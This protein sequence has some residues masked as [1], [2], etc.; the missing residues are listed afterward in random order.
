MKIALIIER[1]DIRLGG[2]ERSISELSHAMIQQGLDVTLLAAQGRAGE[3]PSE[4]LCG[5]S[6][7]R[8]DHTTF[9]EALRRHLSNHSYDITHT[10]LPFGFA[11]IYQPRG[12]SYA[13]T[14]LRTAASHETPLK[15]WVKRITAFTNRRRQQWFAAERS[16][17]TG[18]EG[19]VIAA[20]SKYV[21]QQFK[22]HYNTPED[23]L[24]LIANGVNTDQPTD[25]DAVAQFTQDVRRQ[26]E[27]SPQSEP[28]FYL[29]GAHN[30]RLKGLAP[31]LTAFAQSAQPNRFL[32]VAGHGNERPFRQTIE[33]HRLERNVL[34]LGAT[35]QMQQALAASHVA[36]LPTFYDPASRFILEALAARKPVITT[37]FNGAC[38]LF[39]S[40]RHG[41]IVD[42]PG[43]IP[44]LANALDR[45]GQEGTRQAMTQAIAEDNLKENLS[46]ERVARE[47][48]ALYTSILKKKGSL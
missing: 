25:A 39:T 19:P 28:V 45:L 11:D 29:F 26:L 34:F 43:N 44:A 40:E 1:M 14:I 4:I 23:R 12:G 31:L 37:S 22:R 27:I 20:L 16:L 35:S 38:D 36:V 30:F 9:A 24:A 18:P 48:I 13:E 6:G 7:K 21:V 3:I 32:L 8:T 42:A 46:I 15:E 33:A 41:I 5:D 17:S 2:A 10:V 47:L